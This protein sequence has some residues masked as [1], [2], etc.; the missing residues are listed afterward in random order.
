M[1]MG[2]GMGAQQQSAAAAHPL[3]GQTINVVLVAGQ[4]NAEGRVE[5]TALDASAWIKSSTAVSGVYQWN[6]TEIESYNTA[7]VGQ[8]GNGKCW[9]DGTPRNHAYVAARYGEVEEAIHLVADTIPNIVV[10]QVTNGWSQLHAAETAPNPGCGSWAAAFS[11]ETG[12]VTG[13][14]EIAL[15]KALRDRYNDLL[16]YCTENNIT[17]NPLALI[18]SQGE[19]DAVNGYGEEYADNFDA[20]KLAV[21]TFTD[22]TNLP[23]IA[24]TV[25]KLGDDSAPDGPIWS[26]DIEAAHMDIAET[27]DYICCRYNGALTLLAE[28]SS[29]IEDNYHFDAASVLAF[30][31]FIAGALFAKYANPT[32][33]GDGMFHAARIY[34]AGDV[35]GDIAQ[36]DADIAEL[37]SLGVWDDTGLFLSILG[38]RKI[39]DGSL[40][41]LYNIKNHKIAFSGVNVGLA[42]E[43]FYYDFPPTPGHVPEAL[44]TYSAETGDATFGG[45]AN[46]CLYG[47][48]AALD[49]TSGI[50]G[51]TVFVVAKVSNVSAK[52]NTLFYA[53]QGTSNSGRVYL[54]RNVAHKNLAGSRKIDGDMGVYAE[55]TTASGADGSADA[56]FSVFTAKLDYVAELVSVFRNGQV[57]GADGIA[58]V[59]AAAWAAGATSSATRS[60]GTSIG[61][62]HSRANEVLADSYVADYDGTAIIRDVIVIRAALSDEVR[63]AIEDYLMEKWSLT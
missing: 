2:M 7:D 30:G 36:I 24:G 39:S 34:E 16:D 15:L 46:R 49:I 31:K 59:N 37:K 60:L 38:G 54:G 13:T 17:V 6:G 23:I 48:Y 52:H 40:S 22:S 19:T 41:K 61:A 3:A 62:A 56:V 9:I 45:S 43:Q 47:R 26:A 14:S 11:E 42:T 53:S 20:L 55:A 4:S 12:L 27:D 35:V 1:R 33:R 29:G 21:R 8:L 32:L 63:E 58:D 10:V 25:S 44:P 5:I 51:A 28:G 50:G 57:G 18:W